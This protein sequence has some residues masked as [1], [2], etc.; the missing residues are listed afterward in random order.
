ML[1]RLDDDIERTHNKMIKIDSK[2]K[3]LIASSKTC[4]LWIIIIIEIIAW[5]G[6]FFIP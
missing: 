3:K 6:C 4:C 5:I 2:L 1:D